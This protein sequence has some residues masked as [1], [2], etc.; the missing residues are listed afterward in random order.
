MHVLLPIFL[1]GQVVVAA[2][3]AAGFYIER[4]AGE[5]FPS[6]EGEFL[7]GRVLICNGICAACLLAMGA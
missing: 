3:V 5:P 6:H 4:T 7:L 1:C 2:M